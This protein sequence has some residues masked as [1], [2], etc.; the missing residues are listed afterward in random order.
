MKPWVILTSLTLSACTTSHGFV[1]YETSGIY[2][3]ENAGNR[4]FKDV[5]PVSV[6]VRTFAWESC[7]KLAGRAVSELLD[8]AKTRGGT[9]VYNIKFDTGDNLVTSPTCST[10]WGWFALYIVGGL[11]PWVQ[12]I[13][14]EGVAAKVDGEKTA[15]Q[16]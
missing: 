4:K 14:V 3:S 11:G 8:V 16:N 7:D 13:S 9:T 15:L 12:T 1:N 5:G 6:N 2:S 10:G